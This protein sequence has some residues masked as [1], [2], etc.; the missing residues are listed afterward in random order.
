MFRQTLF[1]PIWQDLKKT[2]FPVKF[3][4]KG[5]WPLK[6]LQEALLLRFLFW[7]EMN[8]MI[9]IN[10]VSCCPEF[11]QIALGPRALQV[12]KL[13]CRENN[14]ETNDERWKWVAD[15]RKPPGFIWERR[16]WWWLD[17]WQPTTADSSYRRLSFDRGASEWSRAMQ[18]LY[19]DRLHVSLEKVYTK[20]FQEM[21]S[22]RNRS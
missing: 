1:F 20:V 13:H 8:G 4:T 15:M 21:F 19:I 9:I 16:P 6:Q 5:P 2:D 12:T 18:S 10:K 17:S 11:M 7:T 14:S 3:A 22:Q